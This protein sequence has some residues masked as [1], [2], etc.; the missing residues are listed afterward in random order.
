LH[1]RY[2]LLVTRAQQREQDRLFV[3]KVLVDG[4][5]AIL[6]ALCHP[7]SRDSL[8]PF[9]GG[10]LLRSGDNALSNLLLFSFPAL[11]DPP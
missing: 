3:L 8:P 1:R 6:D 9:L 4:G 11:F 5:L 2:Q 10:N 7:A